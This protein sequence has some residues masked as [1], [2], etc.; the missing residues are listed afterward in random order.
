MLERQAE[1]YRLLGGELHLEK[2]PE[3]LID[4][5][6]EH[7]LRILEVRQDDRPTAPAVLLSEISRPSNIFSALRS[8]FARCLYAFVPQLVRTKCFN[9]PLSPEPSH[10]TSWLTGLRGIAAMM[11]FNRH[12]SAPFTLTTYV[13]Y[14]AT[15]TDTWVHQ[16]PVFE[17]LYD[18]LLGV[19]IFFTISGYVCSVKSLRAMAEGDSILRSLP[20]SA[21]G[22]WFRLYLPVI[23][24]TFLI[25]SLFRIGAMNPARAFLEDFDD[26]KLFPGR[27]PFGVAERYPPD[28]PQFSHWLA[29]MIE[30]TNP[31]TLDPKNLLNRYLWTIVEE[32]R[33]SM[34]LYIT[35]IVLS[36]CRSWT[37]IPILVLLSVLFA[38]PW[39]HWPPLAFFAGATL[40]QMDVSRAMRA[41]AKASRSAVV[42]T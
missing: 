40:A 28:M 35:L 25:F 4:P 16:L 22:R 37:R 32:Y 21:F 6:L 26:L 14:G 8:L 10:S 36:I 20:A 34:T 18:G 9:D 33:S 1:Q 42:T 5:N 38:G 2:G 7:E 39:Q 30:I 13:R 17:M 27:P 3:G 15:P 24:S 11:V 41:T 19:V 29:A 23:C 12:Y 31:W